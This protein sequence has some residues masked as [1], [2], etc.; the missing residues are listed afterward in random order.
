MD[1]ESGSH[2]VA[3]SIISQGRKS[4][5]PSSDRK[6]FKSRKE[7]KYAMIST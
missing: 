5:F 3:G 6:Q 7:S 2:K 1:T 4:H